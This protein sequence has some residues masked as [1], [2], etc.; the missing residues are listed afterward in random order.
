MS[1]VEGLESAKA[2]LLNTLDELVG[3]ILEDELEGETRS[4]GTVLERTE[5]IIIELDSTLFDKSRIEHPKLRTCAATHG[6]SGYI[7][8]PES[9]AIGLATYHHHPVDGDLSRATEDTRDDLPPPTDA[10][11]SLADLLPYSPHVKLPKVLLQRFNGKLTRWM[12]FWDTESAFHNP[13]LTNIDMFR[14][15]NSL[16]E[17]TASDAIAHEPN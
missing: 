16:L 15:M 11:S 10:R 9:L 13:A 12:T 5:L 6:P 8:R 1:A 4:A 3:A 14:Y 7:E 2:E 17:S